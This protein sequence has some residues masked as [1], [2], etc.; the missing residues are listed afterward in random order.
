MHTSTNNIRDLDMVLNS[1]SF[2]LMQLYK[3]FWYKHKTTKNR[4]V[5]CCL[6]IEAFAYIDFLTCFIKNFFHS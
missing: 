1:I 5:A 6:K 4:Y 3:Q 2:N